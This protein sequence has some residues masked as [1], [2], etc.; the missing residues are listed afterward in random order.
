[1]GGR[2]LTSIELAFTASFVFGWLDVGWDII[3]IFGRLLDT[4]NIPKGSS[5]AS[6]DPYECEARDPLSVISF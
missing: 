5:T 6:R 2:R 1:M 3:F 4:M